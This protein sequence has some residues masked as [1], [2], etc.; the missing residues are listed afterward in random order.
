M[1]RKILFA[2]S[3]IFIA[4][5]FNSCEAL[6]NCKTCKQVTYIDGVYD[7]EGDSNDYCGAELLGIEAMDDFILDNVR[8]AWECN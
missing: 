7:H 3:L 1:K 6:S 5:A 8:T 2:G 4:W